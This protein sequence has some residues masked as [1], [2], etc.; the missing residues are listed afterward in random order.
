[1]AGDLA[2]LAASRI[3]GIGVD[4]HAGLAGCSDTATGAG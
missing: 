2:R 1:M 3:G 4:L